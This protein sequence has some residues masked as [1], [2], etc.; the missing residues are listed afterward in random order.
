M[1]NFVSWQMTQLITLPTSL[2]LLSLPYLLSRDQFI[3]TFYKSKLFNLYYISASLHDIEWLLNPPL[4]DLRG[5]LGKI[6]NFWYFWQCR[7]I[8]C[9][10]I[11][12][13]RTVSHF[14]SLP[15]FERFGTT[16]MTRSTLT[17]SFFHTYKYE[18]SICRYIRLNDVMYQMYID[19]ISTPP[20]FGAQVLLKDFWW[21]FLQLMFV[22]RILPLNFSAHILLLK[23]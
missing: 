10:S 17:F 3:K 16:Q 22:V 6:F 15:T 19:P 4:N 18:R 7:S 13:P 5:F 8:F 12:T 1:T 14:A 11:E 9:L 23:L 21:M 20:F 2:I